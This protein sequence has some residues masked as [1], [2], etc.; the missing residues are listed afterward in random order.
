MSLPVDLAS[1]RRL[2]DQLKKETK[3]QQG[4]GLYCR[5][6][7]E[8]ADLWPKFGF[9]AVNSKTGEEK[10]GQ[11]LFP[12][13][14]AMAIGTCSLVHRNQ[15]RFGRASSL[16]RTYSYDLNF[17]D[18]PESEDSKALLA[19]WVQASVELVITKELSN[20]IADA[21]TVEQRKI[22]RSRTTLYSNYP[23]TTPISRGFAVNC[24]FASLKHPPTRQSRPA[25]GRIRNCGW[26]TVHGDS[27]RNL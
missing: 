11:S 24:A 14:S 20:E 19:D 22:G 17:R 9:E 13:G 23:P 4:I 8:A 1:L 15:T 7:W 5:S 25:T 12:G 21:P 16:M 6:D 27:R 10:M 3:S 26:S 2:V 18:T